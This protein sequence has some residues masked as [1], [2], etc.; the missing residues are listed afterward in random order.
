MNVLRRLHKLV[1]STPIYVQSVIMRLS[2]TDDG[3][4]KVYLAS[5]TKWAE[6]SVETDE[7]SKLLTKKLEQQIP[8]LALS[9][10]KKSRKRNL[11]VNLKAID[12][13]QAGLINY[14]ILSQDDAKPNGVHVADSE[15]LINQVKTFGLTNQV[16][17]QP[18]A[19]E[20]SMLLL[21]RALG[22]LHSFK[23][24]IKAIYSSEI[25]SKKLMP[26]EDRLLNQTV[27]YYITTVGALEVQDSSFA[28]LLFYV[29][30]SR[31]EQGSAV[32]FAQKIEIAVSKGARVMVADI[33]PRGDVQGGDTDFTMT[34]LHRKLIPRLY[35]YA[36]W[37]T[38]GNTVGTT[39]PQ[40]FIF[41]LAKAKLFEPKR[42][43]NSQLQL[44]EDWFT[45]HRVLDDYYYHNLVRAKA[46]RFIAENKWDS[47]LLTKDATVKVEELSKTW[48][49]LDFAELSA[50][51]RLTKPA[52]SSSP[53]FR[54]SNLTFRLPWQRTFEAKIDFTY[55]TIQP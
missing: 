10:Y 37:N 54:P 34:L 2:P 14:L 33:D 29:Y 12:F 23:P 3:E 53:E 49:D 25:L 9:D 48:L 8:A 47:N 13:V 5:L 16:I 31:F 1:P 19:D 45:F 20:V 32:K 50:A 11:N 43:T 42:P 39:L 24:R 52:T 28:D 6:V 15:I 18:G 55:D 51:Y 38:A 22:K 17:I 40:G 35:S 27:S 36:S 30:V 44:A 41:A 4:N 26:Y 46:K 21:A 7:R